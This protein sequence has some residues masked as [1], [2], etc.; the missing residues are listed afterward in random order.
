MAAKSTLAVEVAPKEEVFE[1]PKVMVMI[2]LLPEDKAGLKID[3]YEHVTVNGETTLIRR[4]ERV[5]VPVPVYIQL[6]N[7]FDNI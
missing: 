2:P 4:G 1:E 5:E 7:K 3:Q 6:R